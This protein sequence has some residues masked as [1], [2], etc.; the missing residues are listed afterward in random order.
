LFGKIGFDYFLEVSK[1]LDEIVRKNRENIST[2]VL[3]CEDEPTYNWCRVGI[4]CDFTDQALKRR[5]T[6]DLDKYDRGVWTRAL[7]SQL[8][9]S[10]P[11]DTDCFMITL[12]Y[13]YRDS[14][15]LCFRGQCVDGSTL[16]NI[17]EQ[18][19]KSSFSHRLGRGYTKTDINDYWRIRGACAIS[20]MDFPLIN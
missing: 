20:S 6:Y 19:G 8:T 13:D 4:V 3:T 7:S 11:L 12:K 2:K 17:S 10:T 1:K 16:K 14:K 15:R 5:K 9:I 18:F